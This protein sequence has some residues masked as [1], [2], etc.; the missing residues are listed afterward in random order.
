MLHLHQPTEESLCLPLESIW[1]ANEPLM[2][3]PT[4]PQEGLFEVQPSLPSLPIFPPIS[5][6][7]H[8]P[9]GFLKIDEDNALEL[10][11]C[12]DH[13][14]SADPNLIHMHQ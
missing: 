13:H 5:K 9:Q 3:R 1:L 4:A 11:T 2:I 10:A 14:L 6:F 8:F 12:S 7:F